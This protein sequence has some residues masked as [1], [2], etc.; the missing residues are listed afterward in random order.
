MHHKL[1]GYKCIHVYVCVVVVVC[2]CACRLGGVMCACHTVCDCAY[3]G[4]LVYVCVGVCVHVCVHVCVYVCMC[5]FARAHRC[6]CAG[7]C[8]PD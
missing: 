3:A 6:A 8:V 4:A 1:M 2:T 7:A 5:M